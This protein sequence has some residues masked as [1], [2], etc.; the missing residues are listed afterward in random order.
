MAASMEPTDSVPIARPLPNKAALPGALRPFRPSVVRWIG[1]AVFSASASILGLAAW[2]QPHPS[3]FGTHRQLGFAPCGILV[4][5][6]LPCPTCGM[7]TAFAHTVRGQ[8]LR[9]ARVQPGGF[10]ICLSAMAA[11]VLAL[12]ALWSGDLPQPLKRRLDLY[13]LFWAI[14]IAV[15]GGWGARLLIGLATGELPLA[16]P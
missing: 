9:A 8:W 1:L 15:L 13:Y 11:A 16:S 12:A 14:L 4:R 3:G 2:L 7:T 5:Y 6:R 10:V